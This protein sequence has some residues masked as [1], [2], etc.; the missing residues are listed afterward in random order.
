M[1]NRKGAISFIFAPFSIFYLVKKKKATRNSN[2]LNIIKV[3][4]ILI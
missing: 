1:F 4:K 3:S 2:L